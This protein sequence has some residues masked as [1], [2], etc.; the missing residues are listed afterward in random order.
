MAPRIAFVVEAHDL[1]IRQPHYIADAHLAAP[2]RIGA[3]NYDGWQPSKVEDLVVVH[4]YVGADIPFEPGRLHRNSGQ[5]K[6]DAFV[7]HL[8]DIFDTLGVARGRANRYLHD[9]VGRML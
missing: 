4:C 2:A 3:A 1:S 5:L 7:A 6:L 8:T 9:V